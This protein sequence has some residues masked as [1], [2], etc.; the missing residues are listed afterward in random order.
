MKLGELAR[1]YDFK[2]SDVDL[3]ILEQEHHTNRIRF[4]APPRTPHQY[5]PDQQFN[6][7]IYPYITVELKSKE[8][9]DCKIGNYCW[10]TSCPK[11]T[12]NLPS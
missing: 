2:L 9:L 11:A 5:H 3:I 6:E 8:I 4:L 10:M 12:G 7:L 1:L